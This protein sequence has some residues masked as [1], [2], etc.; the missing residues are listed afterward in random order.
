MMLY[1][2]GQRCIHQSLRLH[3]RQSYPNE[4]SC[5]FYMAGDATH[6]TK[7]C[8]TPF[9]SSTNYFSI[10]SFIMSKAPTLTRMLW[11]GQASVS[12][13]IKNMHSKVEL[14]S[15]QYFFQGTSSYHVPSDSVKLKG[16]ERIEIKI[17]PDCLVSTGAL[18]YRLTG[19]RVSLSS[20]LYMI[21]AWQL[22]Y[23]KDPLVYVVLVEHAPNAIKWNVM[24]S[25]R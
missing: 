17:D 20:S 4:Q 7:P 25:A 9:F 2:I 15:L 24:V 21:I 10:V 13:S 16:D 5:M 19:G 12:V 1:N 14:V 6:Q 22:E 3:I 11:D 18:M 23:L 8:P